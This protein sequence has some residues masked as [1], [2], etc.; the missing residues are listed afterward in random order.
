LPS[1]TGFAASGPIAPNPSTAVAIGDHRDQIAARGQ[2]ARLYRVCHDG[3]A[4]RRHSGRIGQRKVALG[5]HRLARG[6]GDLARRGLAVVL[7]CGYT[8]LLVHYFY[9]HCQTELRGLYRRQGDDLFSCAEVKRLL[10][11]LT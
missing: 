11:D 3:L 7:Q 6:N 9:F 8:Q 10:V 5:D 1:I 2:V 4:G